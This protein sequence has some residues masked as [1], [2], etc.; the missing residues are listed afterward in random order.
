MTQI[1]NL[2]RAFLIGVLLIPIVIIL[3]A[4]I[5]A[6]SILLFIG[7]VRYIQQDIEKDGLKNAK[8]SK[9]RISSRSRF[10]NWVRRM[11]KGD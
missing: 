4:V 6:C 11:G 8:S 3:L 7:L 2:F 1:K 5:G 9:E 10:N